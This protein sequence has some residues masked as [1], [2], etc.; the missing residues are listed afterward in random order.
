MHR[1]E[2]LDGGEAS[3]PVLVTRENGSK[4]V[5]KRS[6]AAVEAGMLRAMADAGVPTPV[7]ERDDADLIILQYVENDEVFGLA[8]WSDLGRQLRQLHAATGEQYG[9]PVDFAIGTVPISN[10]PATN[11]TEF[12]VEERL[13]AMAKALEP[14]W[15]HRVSK[16]IA[17]AGA[18]LPDAPRPCLLHGDLWTGNILV[19]RGMV[20][21]LIDPACY[22][23]D[24]EVDL[25]MLTLFEQPPAEFWA[26]YG[27]V[28]SDAE[29]RRPLYQLFP[30]LLHLRLHKSP[31]YNLADRLLRS[32]NA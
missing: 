9:W 5:A 15:E 13:L 26:A 24:G 23:G 11:W 22:F 30:A 19:H 7:I 2:R 21:A 3:E 10:R 31:D 25:A 8:A 27:P 16:A 4:S 28:A 6:L 18:L 17:G 1:L 32:L 12:W 29:A 14:F 20:A